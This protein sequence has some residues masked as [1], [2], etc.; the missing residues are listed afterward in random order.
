VSK[1]GSGLKGVVFRNIEPG[2]AQKFGVAQGEVLIS[3]NDEKVETKAD[4]LAVGK[5]QYNRG[6]RTFVAKFLSNGQVIER[7]YQLPDR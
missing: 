3:L 5:R 1:T 4:A 7:S 2:I 6:T